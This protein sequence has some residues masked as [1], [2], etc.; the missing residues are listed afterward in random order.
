[1]TA[2]DRLTSGLKQLNNAIELTQQQLDQL[3]IYYDNL[4][5]WNAV[6]N[7]TAITEETDVYEK[8]FLDS[9]SIVIRPDL[10]K[11]T[12][13]EFKSLSLS[14]NE[15]ISSGE[16]KRLGDTIQLIDVGTGAGFPG[17]VIAIAFPEIQVTLMDA[18]NKRIHFLEDTVSQLGIHN[19]TCVHSRAE[20]LARNREY[21]EQ[22]DI[23]VSRAVANISTLSEY[24]IPFVKTGGRF[25]SYKGDDVTEEL[26]GAERAIRLLGGKQ[27]A[28]ERFNLPGTDYKRTL[29]YIMKEHATPLKY[30]RKAGVPSKEPLS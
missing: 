29:I 20:D 18:L 24:C 2:E 22:F 10:W 19:V 26:K 17:L 13:S 5:K 6:M 1:M 30:P 11:K 15:I 28:T 7:L 9:L 27:E 4:V 25:I 21:R 8:H 23:A 3:R 16:S 12:N 14:E